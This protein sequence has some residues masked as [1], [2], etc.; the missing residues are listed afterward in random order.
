MSSRCTCCTRNIHLRLTF[1]MTELR[2]RATVAPSPRNPP[3]AA[4]PTRRELLV[5][6]FRYL[7]PAHCFSH[8]RTPG[9]VLVVCPSSLRF[10]MICG[11]GWAVLWLAVSRLFL[12]M[13]DMFR[14]AASTKR[15][16]KFRDL[17]VPSFCCVFLVWFVRQLKLK[18][19]EINQ[20]PFRQ[21]LLD[22]I[23]TADDGGGGGGGGGGSGDISED[24]SWGF[25]QTFFGEEGDGDD[26]PD[27]YDDI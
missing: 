15:R 9:D 22:S 2:H 10:A 13:T 25:D 14:C 24:M 19:E 11:L 7:F 21:G 17:I 20:N 3:L 4:R 6:A 16:S 5:E 23:D 1:R 12:N 18:L 26:E 8:G 27:D